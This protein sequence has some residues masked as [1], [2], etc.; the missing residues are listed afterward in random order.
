MVSKRNW[1]CIFASILVVAGCATPERIV[2]LPQADGKPSAVIVESRAGKVVLDKP[3]AMADVSSSSI[4]PGATNAAAVNERYADIQKS[5][6]PRP[7]IYTLYFILGTTKL[8]AESNAQL[9]SILEQMKKIPAADAIIVGHADMVGTD[10]VNDKLSRDRAEW[11]KNLLIKKGVD[12]DHVEAV[13]RGSREPLI[14][15]KRG[16]EEP[17]N[18]RVEIRVR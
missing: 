10:A 2:L 17:K 9:D 14:P 11:V 5:M 6:P 1:L 3:Y 12:I 7:T 4:K 15:A 13:G 16:V 18:R 8:T